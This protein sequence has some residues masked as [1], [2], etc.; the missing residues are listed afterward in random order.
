MV[1]YIKALRISPL[2]LTLPFL[3]LTPLFLIL[4]S[5]G[6]LG[7]KVSL[8][9]GIGIIFLAAGGYTL[10]LHEAKR[11]MFEPFKAIT[12]EKG[13]LLMIGV[14]MIYSFTSSLG[15]MAIIHSSP[16]FF[17]IAYFVAVTIIFTPIALWF[18]RKDIKYF[19]SERQFKG[20]ILPGIFFSI[21]IGSHMIAISLTK[22]AYMISVK[23]ISLI[24]G[25]VYG[26]ILFRE[27]NIKER[28][29]GAL[30]ML[31]GFVL[32]VTAP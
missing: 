18:G 6:I 2:S 16:L 7:E 11:G 14:A 31:V 5:H 1:L 3:S 15:K 25:L 28:L 29:S 27:K 13:S 22:V 17:G 10:N 24:I 8:Q 4:V 32:I 23:R 21:M 9:G 19:V 12:K 26:Y 30:L 20:L